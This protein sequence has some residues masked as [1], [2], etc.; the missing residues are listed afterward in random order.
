MINE[1]GFQKLSKFRADVCGIWLQFDLVA[2]CS[3][4]W[5]VSVKPYVYVY[6][7]QV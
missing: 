4:L 1:L 3:F 5:Y 6:A 7:R 2:Y